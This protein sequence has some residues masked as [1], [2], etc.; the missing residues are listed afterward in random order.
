MEWPE[1]SGC[2]VQMFS[3]IHSLAFHEL[4]YLIQRSGE[5]QEFLGFP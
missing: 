5:K 1:V 3:T 4:S 2:S